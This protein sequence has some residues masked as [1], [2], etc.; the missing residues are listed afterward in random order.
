[1]SRD[2]AGAAGSAR[3]AAR[4][5]RRGDSRRVSR[6]RAR[7]GA[8]VPLSHR[9]DHPKTVLALPEVQLGLIPGVGGTQRL[10]RRVGLQAALDMILTGRNVRAKKA[11]QMGL[12]DEMVHPAILRDIAIDRAREAGR[13]DA[14]ARS[15]ARGRTAHGRLLLEHNPIGRARGVQEGARERDGEDARPLSRAARRARGG[16]G[17]LLAA[18]SRQG[19]REEARLFGEMA[20]TDV[21]RQLV[22]LFFASNALKKDRASTTPAPPPRR[23]EE[24]RR[25]RRRLH[26]R[27]HRVDRRAAGHARAAQ[28]HRHRAR[29]ERARRRERGAQERLKRKQ[30]TRQQLDDT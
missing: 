16:A 1:M 8:R 17:R 27:G 29:R 24:A 22:F 21:S 30:I 20:V 14:S 2:R 4:A 19:L 15:A 11:L 23:R 18:A 26:G 13:R 10:P 5:R 7:G 28:G 6:R 9:T 3:E 12:V 25:A